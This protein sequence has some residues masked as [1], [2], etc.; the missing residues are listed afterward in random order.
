MIFKPSHMQ[1]KKLNCQ[2]STSFKQFF[3]FDQNHLQN[4]SG[5]SRGGGGPSFRP[6]WG[7][8][9]RKVF[10][11]PPT[12]PPP[13]PLFS[14][15][16]DDCPPL[17]SR[18]GSGP[19]YPWIAIIKTKSATIAFFSSPPVRFSSLFLLFFYFS[20]AGA[21]I[22]ELIRRKKPTLWPFFNQMAV[23]FVRFVFKRCARNINFCKQNTAMLIAKQLSMA[24]IPLCFASGVVQCSTISIAVFFLQ[25]LMSTCYFCWSGVYRSYVLR[26]I[27]LRSFAVLCV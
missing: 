17:I 5:G 23:N 14:K 2:I 27:R 10:W 25:N 15:G 22:I 7:P 18:F 21:G 8:K 3:F 9:G 6:N 20:F 4:S 11:R 1:F 12:P 24:T 26:H 13:P 16:L 19:E